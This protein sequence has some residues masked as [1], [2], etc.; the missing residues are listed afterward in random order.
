MGRVGGRTCR[1]GGRRAARIDKQKRK[2]REG[3]IH[4]PT[5]PML[6]AHGLARTPMWL[7]WR[8]SLGSLVCA[9]GTGEVCGVGREAHGGPGFFVSWSRFGIVR[10]TTIY[11]MEADGFH[12]PRVSK[13]S[14]G[15][16][17]GKSVQK[18]AIRFAES[19]SGRR[20]IQCSGSLTPL[21]SLS[22]PPPSS[23]TS[24]SARVRF[25]VSFLVCASVLPLPPSLPFTLSLAHLR[26]TYSRCRSVIR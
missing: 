17:E 8:C 26:L 24:P 9:V 11:T 1:G 5:Q 19:V 25:H 23:L 13:D 15:T 22:L 4:L 7:R 10:P 6:H 14:E 12:C 2:G 21:P 16:K 3:C 18:T 20:A